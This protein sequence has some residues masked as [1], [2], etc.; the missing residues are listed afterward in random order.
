M[1]LETLSL[2]AVASIEDLEFRECVETLNEFTLRG[3]A[4]SG[5]APLA[6]PRQLGRA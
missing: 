3:L 6:H 5:K 2:D 4:K 1:I